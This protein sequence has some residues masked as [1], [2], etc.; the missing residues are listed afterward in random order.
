MKKLLL[1]SISMIA[2]FAFIV[3][4]VTYMQVKTDDGK[5][6]R[7]DVKHVTEVNFE[8]DTQETELLQVTVSGTI[9]KDTY[10]DLGLPSGTKWA[11]YNVGAKKPEGIGTYF[12]WAE[13]TPDDITLSD[14]Y[15]WSQYK[16]GGYYSQK[17]YVTIEEW[18]T[19]DSITVLLPEDDA[20][21][22]NFSSEWRTPSS[23]E[24]KELI[25][26]CTWTHVENFNNT[27]VSGE[28][29]VSKKNGNTI[30][31][32]S[33]GYRSKYGLSASYC[34]YYWSSDLNQEDNGTAYLT[35]FSSEGFTIMYQGR[36]DGMVVRPVSNAK[37]IESYVLHVTVSGTVGEN[38][39]VDL[40]LPSGTKWATYNVGADK[41][42]GI[43]THFSWAEI[44]PDDT[45]L[46]DCYSWSQYKWGGL[47]SQKKYVTLTNWGTVDNNTVLLPEDDAAT[48]NF[49]S[50][51]RTP[52]SAEQKELIDGCIWTYVENVNNTGVSGMVG[53]SKANGNIIF[54]PSSGYRAKYGWG[55]KSNGYYWSSDL[56]QE[57]NGT[58]YL[59]KFTSEGFTIM[60]QGRHDG[61]VVRPVTNAEE[62]IEIKPYILEVTVTD[63][64]GGNTYVDLGLPSG[65]KWATCNVGATKPEEIGTHFS[66]AETVPDDTTLSDCYS[67][68]QYK[69][70]GLYSQKKYVTLTNWGTVDN[71]TVL[72]PEDDAAT[73]NI[74]SEWRTP[75]SADQKELIDGCTWTYVENVNNTGISG[76]VGVSKTNGNIIFLPSSGY[77]SRYGLSASYSGYYW[78][79][80]LNQKDNGTA[81]LTKFTSEGFTIMYQGRHDGMIVR[82]VTTK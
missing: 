80:D 41:P 50:E 82:P 10:V 8:E 69:W 44:T 53:M 43:G 56:N 3:N 39:Y 13:T 2:S 59:A 1:L 52:S 55:A 36:H 11:T 7:Y 18:G 35:K 33:S 24:Q 25:D 81:Y 67:W 15:S 49:S 68:S 30:F 60:Y 48:Q 42:E 6:V 78:S 9:G 66:W 14:C 76:R 31:L 51:W 32:P 28:Y 65:T 20:A 70:G 79:S 19:V 5:V 74:G 47:Y 71:N 34:G 62:K 75:S 29:G 26:G 57:D 63:S 73:Q 21:T 45:T 16:W 77:R 38:T 27:G 46:S 17:K 23:A 54:L 40:G 37:D 12:S 72:L 4:A 61:M 22:V 64:I 58:A